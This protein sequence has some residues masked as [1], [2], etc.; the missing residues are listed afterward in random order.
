M[1]N[2]LLQAAMNRLLKRPEI[3]D[4]TIPESFEHIAKYEDFDILKTIKGDFKTWEMKTRNSDSVIGLILGGRGVGKTA[5]GVKFLENARVLQNKKYFNTMGFEK[6]RL[7]DWITNINDTSEL[8]NNSWLLVD[9]AGISFNSK[10]SH[11]KINQIL[12]EL[13]F[14][15]RHKNLSVLFISQNSANIDLDALRQADFLILKTPSLLQQRFERKLVQELYTEQ[16][17]NFK[18]FRGDPG[19]TFIFSTEFQGYISNKLPTFWSDSLSK[20]YR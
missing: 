1:K 6:E 15:S 13:L 14:I 19:L 7:P 20:S 3:V 2:S 5:F 8:K 11:G 9:E 10:K 17:D 4:V 18:K 12:R 16:E